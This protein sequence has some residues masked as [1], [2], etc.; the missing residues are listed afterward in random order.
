MQRKE[1]LQLDLFQPNDFNYQYKAVVTNKTTGAANTVEYHKGRGTQESIFAEL[2][3]HMT[4]GYVP[5][6]SWNANKLYLL[7][8]LF[9]HNLTQELQMQYKER[10]RITTTKRPAL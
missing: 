4:L 7:C 9:A 1:P 3:S 10:D 6:N 2:K 5:C 8:K